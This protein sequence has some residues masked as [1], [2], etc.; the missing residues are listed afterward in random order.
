ML[1]REVGTQWEDDGNRGWMDA[2]SPCHDNLGSMKW[3]GKKKE[4]ELKNESKR[5]MQKHIPM[6]AMMTVVGGRV[7]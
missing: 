3:R 4:H 7:K 1:K 6:N 5:G 2:K